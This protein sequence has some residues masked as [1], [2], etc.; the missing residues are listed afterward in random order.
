MAAVIPR[1][2]LSENVKNL[3]K[4]PPVPSN[5]PTAADLAAGIRLTNDLL[6][7]RRRY[8]PSQ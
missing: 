7:I 1:P 8:P 3:V 4:Y 2:V 6:A 5:P